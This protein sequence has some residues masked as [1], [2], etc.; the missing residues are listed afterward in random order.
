MHLFNPATNG[1]NLLKGL[2]PFIQIVDDKTTLG[3]VC[4]SWD[5]IARNNL[6]S[7]KVDNPLLLDTILSKL[8][9]EVLAKSFRRGHDY[10]ITSVQKNTK[11]TWAWLTAATPKQVE[12]M[13]KNQIHTNRK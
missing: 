4:K 2:R 11:E 9:H 12:K 10:E 8:H 1:I 6:L 13:E 7:V 3:K 5:S